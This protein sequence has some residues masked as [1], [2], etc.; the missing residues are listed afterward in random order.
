MRAQPINTGLMNTPQLTASTS[1]TFFP[2]TIKSTLTATL[3]AA[4]AVTGNPAIAEK[5]RLH[6]NLRYTIDYSSR[7]NYFSELNELGF[8]H[9]LGFDVHKVFSEARGDIGTLTAQGYLTRIDNM[10][11]RPGF[12]DDAHDTEFVYRIFNF[13]YTATPKYLPNVKLGHFEVPFGLEYSI[14]TNGTLRDYFSGRNL[15]AKADWGATLNDDLGAFEYELSYST[16][17]GQDFEADDSSSYI[18][19][20]H[21]SSSRDNDIVLGLSFYE[22]NLKGLDRDRIGIDVKWYRGLHAIYFEASAGKNGETDIKTGTLEWNLRN[23]NETRLTYAQLVSFA[24]KSDNTWEENLKAIIGIR[25]APDTH[26]SFSAQVN[27]DLEALSCSTK[28]TV[29]SLQIRYRL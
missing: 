16:G 8:M 25:Y 26:W 22:A 19:A 13:N 21:I 18:T 1:N 29:S 10:P 6:D 20:G 4:C 5:M 11:M 27:H 2:N 3:I 24:K 23:T 17:G 9:A 15:G 14:N 28:E 7:A 12:F